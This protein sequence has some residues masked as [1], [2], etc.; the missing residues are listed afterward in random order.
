MTRTQEGKAI[1]KA[2][3]PDYREGRPPKYDQDQLD[4]AMR[5]LEDHSYTQVVKLTGISRSTLV[6]EKKKRNAVNVADAGLRGSSSVYS[7]A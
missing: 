7:K 2:I 4:H 1:A 3:N 6:R 5:L